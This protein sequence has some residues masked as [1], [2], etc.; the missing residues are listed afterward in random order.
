MK[1]IAAVEDATANQQPLGLPDRVR[2]LL[3]KADGVL[4]DALDYEKRRLAALKAGEPFIEE[5]DERFCET[6]GFYSEKEDWEAEGDWDKVW[7]SDK[8]PQ[9]GQD[10]PAGREET[11]REEEGQGKRAHT[12]SADAVDYGNQA[13]PPVDAR[14]ADGQ[15]E[16]EGPE[17]IRMVPL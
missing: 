15:Y 14:R 2:P 3:E 1:E 13:D 17:G 10:V 8:D 11:T 9:D 6:H 4:E 16:G 5:E 12:E 7:N